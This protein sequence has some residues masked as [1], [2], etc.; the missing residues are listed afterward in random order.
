MRIWLL[1]LVFSFGCLVVQGQQV[2]TEREER[3][4]SIEVPQQS[5]DWLF[6][7]FPGLK[8]AKWY[9]EETSGKESYE[10]KF[11]RAGKKFSVEFS[12]AGLIE[13][14]EI[15]R[16]LAE[17]TPATRQKLEEAFSQFEKF[18]IRKLQEQWTAAS[19]DL[20]QVALLSNNNSAIEVRYE[21]VFKALIEGQH[22]IW[23]GLFDGEGR[24]LEKKRVALRPTD[25]LDF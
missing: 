3:I 23:E 19:P 4:K 9:K 18:K 1:V 13:D 6:K 15:T 5:R 17:L 11:K 21:V 2:K 25:N 16:R 10:A 24:L 20:L 14:V 22:T 8:K 12:E 7:S